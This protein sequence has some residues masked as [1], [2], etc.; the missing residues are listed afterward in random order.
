V[1][2]GDELSASSEVTTEDDTESSALRQ[3]EQ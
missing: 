3:F 2:G 1:V